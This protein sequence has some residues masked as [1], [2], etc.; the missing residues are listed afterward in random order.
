MRIQTIITVLIFTLL[1]ATS[2]AQKV[3]V[4]N[5]DK[6]YAKYEYMDAIRIYERVAGQGYKNAR[7]FQ[8]MG[9]AYYFNGELAKAWTWYKQLFSMDQE[10]DAEYYY[11]YAQTLRSVN[12]YLK[13]DVMMAEFMKRTKEDNRGKIFADQQ[14]YLQKIKSNPNRYEV[15][16]VGVNSKYSD[17]G[18]TIFNNKLV[19]ASARDTT[20]K[21]SKWTNEP[22]TNLY[23]SEIKLTGELGAPIP[24]SK[25]IN[26]KYHESTPIFTKDGK[27]MYFTRNNYLNNKKGKDSTNT[28]LLK[29]YKAVMVKGQWS[30]ITELPFNNDNYS[31]AHP[32]LSVDE[33]TL[34]FSSD[35]PGTLGESDLFR[36]AIYSDGTLGNP[37]N[38]GAKIN[39]E[40]RE[41]FPFVSADSLLYFATDGR[42]G[43]GGLDIFMTKLVN[44]STFKEINNMGETINSPQDDFALLMNQ[45]EQKGFFTSN[46]I[47]GKGK[48]DLY[49]F[50]P[51][52]CE[53]SLS[54][55][56]KDKATGNVLLG[57]KVSL[58]DKHFKLLKDTVLLENGLYEFEVDCGKTYYVRAEKPDYETKEELVGIPSLSGKTTLNIELDLRLKPITVGTDLAKV[59]DIP[60]IYFD[61]DKFNIRKDAAGELAKILVTLQQYPKMKVQVRSHTDSRQTHQYNQVLSERRAK[62]TV[63]WLVK[64]GISANRLTF[65]GYG[66]TK[67]VNQCA[68]G[69]KCSEKEHQA[70]RRSEFIIVS[71]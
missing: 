39:T 46:R 21:I 50:K 62:S 7:M 28:T 59:L 34:Y 5:A 17:Y 18:S 69:V 51:A 32:A 53:Q 2:Y 68:D 14:D 4:Q 22:F 33:K 70:N 19:F 67:L 44:D 66:E 26:S 13:A 27:V 9:N 54:G 55:L 36:V 71:M 48:D 63:A 29:L 40:G 11:R 15:F 16:N 31:V 30:N 23:E 61:L 6:K 20:G 56:I 41:T 60:M 8:H 42:P 1:T 64:K 3:R 47:S 52:P 38:L 24:F 10:P 37:I 65:K 49:R 43:L 35:M 57:V 45:K 58:Y 12:D 25:T